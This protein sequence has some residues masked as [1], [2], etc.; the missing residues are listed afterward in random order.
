MTGVVGVEDKESNLTRVRVVVHAEDRKGQHSA[1]NRYRRALVAF[2]GSG[3]R[4]QGFGFSGLGLRT[5][6]LAV[7]VQGVG[8]RVWIP[9]CQSAAQA[10]G[11]EIRGH[12]LPPRTS[13]SVCG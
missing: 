7:R 1:A 13:F 6:G 9:V 3:F 12:A 10:L 4:V 11:L 8:C 5:Q 2:Q